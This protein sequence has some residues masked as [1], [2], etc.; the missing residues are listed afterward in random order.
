MN[1]YLI[2][3]VIAAEVEAF[4]ENDAR[5]YISDIFGIDDE[6]RKVNIESVKLIKEKK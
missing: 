1:K 4:D 2:K 3:L 5:D 6:V